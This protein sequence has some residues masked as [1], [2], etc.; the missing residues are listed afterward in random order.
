MKLTSDLSLGVT[1]LI[2]TCRIWSLFLK[3][4]RNKYQRTWESSLKL[5]RHAL[6]E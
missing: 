5:T 1:P 4:T 6:E 3:Q 2:Q